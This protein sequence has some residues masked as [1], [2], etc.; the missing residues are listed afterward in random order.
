MNETNKKKGYSNKKKGYYLFHDS[1][2]PYDLGFSAL[3]T[4]KK[5]SK[6]ETKK[7]KKLLCQEKK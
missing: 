3:E 1:Y 7:L 4:S 6:K 5:L 2:L